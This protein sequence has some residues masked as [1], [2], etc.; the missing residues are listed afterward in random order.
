MSLCAIAFLILYI[1]QFT[2]TTGI[3]SG[4][5]LVASYFFQS[6]GE[7]LISALGLSM[8]AELFLRKM[9]RFALGMW[10]LTTMVAGP[11]GGYIGSLTAPPAG[12]VYTKVQSIAVYGDV[13]LTLGG[14]VTVVAIIMWIARGWLNS[15]IESTRIHITAEGLHGMHEETRVLPNTEA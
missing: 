14:F 10:A 12:V 3:V 1:P 7:L 6:T 9:S 4:W 11:I 13:F 15:I 8:V 5:W 2:I